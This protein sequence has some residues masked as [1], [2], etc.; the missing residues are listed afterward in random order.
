MTLVSARSVSNSADNAT[1]EAEADLI[2]HQ[3]PICGVL[4]IEGRS[5]RLLVKTFAPVRVESA[6]LGDGFQ[7]EV[8]QLGI[9]CDGLARLGIQ[10]RV[11]TCRRSAGRR[12]RERIFHEL[13]TES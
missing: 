8:I 2:V 1:I 6:L 9:Q 11:I 12:K 10:M 4:R 5:R 13:I 3:L 7:A